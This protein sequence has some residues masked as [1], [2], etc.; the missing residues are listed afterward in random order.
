[1]SEKPQTEAKK[2]LQAVSVWYEVH[3]GYP[4]DALWRV[5]VLEDGQEMYTWSGSYVT[6]N[7]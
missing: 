4:K 2:V 1:M 6:V 3:P 7:Q 5:D